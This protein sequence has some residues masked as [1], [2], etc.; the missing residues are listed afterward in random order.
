M[1]ARTRACGGGACRFCASELMFIS[2][3][4]GEYRAAHERKR[5]VASCYVNRYKSP[6]A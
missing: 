4:S 5:R 3:A 6:A 1:R 2:L